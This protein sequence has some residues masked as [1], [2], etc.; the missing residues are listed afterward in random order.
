M[1]GEGVSNLYFAD[2][3]SALGECLA[4]NG[5]NA[6]ENDSHR[7]VLELDFSKTPAPA[8][9]L[10]T[11]TFRARYKYSSVPPLSADSFL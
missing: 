9:G 6:G 5:Y 2:V 1:E 11:H 10:Q 8:L 3:I 7:A 4:A